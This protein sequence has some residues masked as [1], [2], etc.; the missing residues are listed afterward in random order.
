MITNNT[1]RCLIV[2]DEPLAIE[3]IETYI[4]NIGGFNVVAKCKNAL[5]AYQILIKEEIDLMFLDIQ[6]P[7]LTG[8]DFL[9]SIENPPKVI[10]TTAYRN[11][12]LEGYELDVID[13]LLKPIRFERFIKAVDKYNSLKK[14]Q[15]HIVSGIQNVDNEKS[16]IYIRS[17]RKTLKIFLKEIIFVEGMK[18]YLLIHTKQSKITTKLQMKELEKILPHDTFLR[19][20]KSFIVSLESITAVTSSSIEIDKKELPIGRN[21]K[22][23][24]LKKL[25][26]H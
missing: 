9:K 15:N 16:F 8:I 23:E 19:I 13:Y 17:D 12:A 6:M 14:A 22:I 24:V 18:D 3:I 11:Y 26:I 10:I 1:I 2:D 7:K 25:N 20:H 4:N 21:Y 5:I